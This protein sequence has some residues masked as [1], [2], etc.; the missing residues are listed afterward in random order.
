M[1]DLLLQTAIL[2]T[3]EK[4][5]NAEQLSAITFRAAHALKMDDRGILKK[6]K[7]ADF[8]GFPGRNYKEILYQ[9]GMLKP[10]MVWKRGL[11]IS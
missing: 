2:G 11:L 1:G 5:T 9:Q 3:F 7:I 8:T 10:S 4:L 6:G